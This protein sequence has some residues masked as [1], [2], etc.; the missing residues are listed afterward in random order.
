MNKSEFEQISCLTKKRY[1]IEPLTTMAMR[2]YP[3]DFCKGWHLASRYKDED[4][5]DAR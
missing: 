3:C 2:A 1:K 5:R 4:E